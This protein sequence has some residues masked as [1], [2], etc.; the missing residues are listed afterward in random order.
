MCK[1]QIRAL[2]MLL[3]I[4]VDLEVIDDDRSYKYFYDLQENYMKRKRNLKTKGIG[5]VV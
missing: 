5:I 1:E 3:T 2:E 4:L